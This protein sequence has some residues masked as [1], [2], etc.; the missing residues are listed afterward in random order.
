MDANSS[1]PLHSLPSTAIGFGDTKTGAWRPFA[2]IYKGGNLSFN[3]P[4]QRRHKVVHRTGCFQAKYYFTSSISLSF[5]VLS[6]HG[7]SGPYNLKSM[8]QP[9]PGIV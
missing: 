4:V 8:F 1:R 7:S 6:N 2:A 9:L 5:Q 3:R